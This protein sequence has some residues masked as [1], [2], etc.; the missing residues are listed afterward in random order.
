MANLTLAHTGNMDIDDAYISNDRLYTSFGK[1]DTGAVTGFSFNPSQ[2]S[3]FICGATYTINAY[4]R[5]SGTVLTETFV[6]SGTD[7]LG[8]RKSDSSVL[9]QNYDTDLTHYDIA[10]GSVGGT[11]I[12]SSVTSDVVSIEFQIDDDEYAE[13]DIQPGSGQVF[14]YPIDNIKVLPGPVVTATSINLIVDSAITNTGVAYV[15]YDPTGATVDIGYS[16]SDTDIA[17]IDSNG[18][19]TVLQNGVVTVCAIDI[20]SGLRDCKQ[21]TMYHSEPPETGDTITA[22]TIQ[23]SNYIVDSGVASALY[24]PNDAVVDLVYSS[25]NTG[26]ATIDQRTGEITVIGEGYVN[27]CVMDNYTGLED[28]KEVFVMRGSPAVGCRMEVVYDF[29]DGEGFVFA[30]LFYGHKRNDSC[31]FYTKIETEDGTDITNSV[32]SWNMNWTGSDSNYWSYRFNSGGIHKL[33]YTLTGGTLTAKFGN[34]SIISVTIPD[35]VTKLGSACF[36]ASEKLMNVYIPQTVTEFVGS[37]QNTVD[38]PS[39]FSGSTF[40]GCQKL[41]SITL[42]SGLTYLPDHCF[43]G[44]GLKSISIHSGITGIGFWCFEGCTSLT[45]ITIPNTVQAIPADCFSDCTSLNAISLP[46]SIKAIRSN[47]FNRT[48]LTEITFPNGLEV[49]G[50]LLLEGSTGITSITF[51]S[52]TPPTTNVSSPTSVFHLRPGETE[53]FPMYVPCESIALYAKAWTYYYDRFECESTG[54]R[55]DGGECIT[56]TTIQVDSVIVDSGNCVVNYYPINAKP[57]YIMSKGV[58]NGEWDMELVSAQPG[59]DTYKITVG[60]SGD[61]S[62]QK[63]WVSIPASTGSCTRSGTTAYFSVERTS[64]TGL[65]LYAYYNVTSTTQS[66]KILHNYAV[67]GIT[68][69]EIVDSGIVFQPATSYTFSSTGVTKVKYTLKNTGSLKNKIGYKWFQNIDSLVKAEIPEGIE[70]FDDNVFEYCTALAEVV[71]PHSLKI[72]GNYD[73]RNTNLTSVT[74]YENVTYPGY[75]TFGF[76]SNLQEVHIYST[77]SGGTFSLALFHNSGLSRIYSHNIQAPS[78]SR[79]TDYTTPKNGVFYYPSGSNY[80]TWESVLGQDGWTGSPTL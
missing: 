66:T 67:S 37:C 50:D 43:N 14:T 2:G 46:N 27:F 26:L 60:Q 39:S 31:V 52:L 36:S 54:F 79:S 41:E 34:V 56:S 70:T 13:L 42:P 7:T 20:I 22:L 63:N 6:V 68:E 58:L 35:C 12:S 15:E 72:L 21:V 16:I 65:Y 78:V 23:V 32:Y 55:F 73:F 80:S 53:T 19:I 47:A 25:T 11:V 71:L 51:T 8:V 69:A 64:G 18:N 57:S 10:I 29:G 77:L 38:T 40:S 17:T 49:V 1:N 75:A 59:I 3:E 45:S 61:G 9:M 4:P 28:C 24:R 30:N 5:F 74:L 33:Y 48:G 76:C 62:S 44:S